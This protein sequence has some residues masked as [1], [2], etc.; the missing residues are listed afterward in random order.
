MTN[1]VPLSDGEIIT[2]SM[3]LTRD[4][5]EHSDDLGDMLLRACD[6]VRVYL[7]EPQEPRA[8]MSA[9]GVALYRNCKGGMLAAFLDCESLPGY[10]LVVSPQCQYSDDYVVRMV[11][12]IEKYGR[13]AVVGVGGG[14]NLEPRGFRPLPAHESLPRDLPIHELDIR[15]IAYHA[16]TIKLARESLGPAAVGTWPNHILAVWAQLYGIPMVA[17]QR[18]NGWVNA[19]VMPR[20]T[21]EA[22]TNYGRV[23]IEITK[24]WVLYAVR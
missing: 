21:T 7:T 15:T 24:P 23:P 4:D 8:W 16:G 13:Q 5:A 9:T 18:Y 17:V 2:A 22:D 10:H 1:V 20:C 6:V 19:P 14:Y 11:H 3:A 12:H